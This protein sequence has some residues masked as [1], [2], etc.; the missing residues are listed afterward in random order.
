MDSDRCPIDTNGRHPLVCAA[1]SVGGSD[2]FLC[3]HPDDATAGASLTTE[4][5]RRLQLPPRHRAAGGWPA[6]GDAD[7]FAQLAIPMQAGCLRDARFKLPAEADGE[8][9]YWQAVTELYQAI[10]SGR[11]FES[12]EHAANTLRQRFS[13]RVIDLQR[14]IGT[15]TRHVV[16][17]SNPASDQWPSPFPR[18]RRRRGRRS[19]AST[20]APCCA[21]SSPTSAGTSAA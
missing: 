14:H 1:L 9:C 4:S 18:P 12:E 8:D 17:G 21:T 7:A 5:D 10:G 19:R 15:V 20:T 11:R 3:P 6:P 16:P 13:S 2:A